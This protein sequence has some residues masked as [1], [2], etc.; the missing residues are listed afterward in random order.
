MDLVPYQTIFETVR[1]NVADDA[2]ATGLVAEALAALDIPARE[3]YPPAEV[4][5]IGTYLLGVSRKAL[6]D[7][8]PG[9]PADVRPLVEAIDPMADALKGALEALVAEEGRKP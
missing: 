7:A 9:V 6:H 4:M 2:T 1:A 5:A 8:A 3:Q